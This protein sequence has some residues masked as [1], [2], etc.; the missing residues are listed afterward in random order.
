MAEEPQSEA[1]P[2]PP[3]GDDAPEDPNVG[4]PKPDGTL[5]FSLSTQ[6]NGDQATPPSYTPEK[7]NTGNGKANDTLGFSR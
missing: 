1:E 5:G 4:K 2:V 6:P 7:P 3:Q